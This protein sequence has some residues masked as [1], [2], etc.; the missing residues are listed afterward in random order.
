MSRTRVLGVVVGILKL[1]GFR[2]RASGYSQYCSS[3][4]VGS[5]VLAL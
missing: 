1:S 4:I 3:M 2:T 5:V